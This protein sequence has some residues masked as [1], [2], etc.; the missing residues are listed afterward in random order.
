MIKIELAAAPITARL[1]FQNQ[2]TTREYT[3]EMK[4]FVKKAEI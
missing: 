3:H 1:S 4:T 2:R